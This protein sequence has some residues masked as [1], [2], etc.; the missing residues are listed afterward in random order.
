VNGMITTTEADPS[1]IADLRAAGVEV[2][3]T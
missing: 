2:E 1:I 3:L